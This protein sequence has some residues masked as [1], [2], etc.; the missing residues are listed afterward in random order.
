MRKLSDSQ[1]AEIR[2]QATEGRSQS[3]IAADFGVSARHVGRIVTGKARPALGGLSRDIA[4]E[5]GV[6]AALENLLAGKAL[7][8]S[9]NVAAETARALARQLDAAS[10]TAA[11]AAAAPALARQLVEIVQ[12]IAGDDRPADALD[13]I[14]AKREARLLAGIAG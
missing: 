2:L 4:A 11:S 3:K 9:Q 14:R 5:A 10:A 6:L 7:S 13:R 8:P 1:V 12:Q